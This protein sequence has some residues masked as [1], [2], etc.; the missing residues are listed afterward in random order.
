MLPR[1]PCLCR[2]STWT[3]SWGVRVTYP[4][5][6]TKWGQTD[7]DSAS[8]VDRRGALF[9][10]LFCASISD[11]VY[12]LSPYVSE[13]LLTDREGIVFA[14]LSNSTG[15]PRYGPMMCHS[16]QTM[17]R[18]LRRHLSFARF[19]KIYLSGVGARVNHEDQMWRIVVRDH[20]FPV[21]PV[22]WLLRLCWEIWWTQCRTLT[23]DSPAGNVW[24]W[25]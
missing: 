9:T 8:I 11:T 20:Y 1:T 15:L 23:A 3:T 13:L 6:G 16:S 22:V 4:R 19:S 2:I 17:R 18:L 12:D 10:G 25:W 21:V 14:P 24:A 7:E 5:P